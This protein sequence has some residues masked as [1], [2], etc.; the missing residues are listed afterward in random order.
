M[1][2]NANDDENDSAAIFIRSLIGKSITCRLHDD[3]SVEGTFT[4]LDQM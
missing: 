3:R 1:F 2:A 4:C